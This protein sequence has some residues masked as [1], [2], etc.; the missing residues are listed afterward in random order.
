ML[1]ALA[2]SD[3]KT[4]GVLFMPPPPRLVGN[5][6]GSRR[7][8]RTSADRSPHDRDAITTSLFPKELGR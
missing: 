2:D 1:I 6:T 8:R 3:R 4:F 5:K 7:D